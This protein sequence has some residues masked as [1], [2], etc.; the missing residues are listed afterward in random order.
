MDARHSEIVDLVDQ[1]KLGRLQKLVIGICA[2]VALLDGFDT[3]A[4]AFTAPSIIADWKIPASALGVAFA[5]GLLGLMISSLVL[6]TLGDRLGR[7]KMIIVSLLVMGV[8]SLLTARATTLAELCLLRF[9][10]G[11]GLGGAIPCIIALTAE[12][13][14]RRLRATLV[15]SMYIGFPVGAVIGGAASTWFIDAY[16]WRSVFI[17]GGLLPLLLIPIVLWLLPESLEIVARRGED[18][19]FRKL[20]AQLSPGADPDRY[21]NAIKSSPV[22]LGSV[23]RL[24]ATGMAAKT[25]SLWL[26][27]FLNLMIMYLLINWLPVFLTTA[28]RQGSGAILGTVVLNLGGAVGGFVIARLMDRNQ[29]HLALRAAFLG[30]AAFL[31]LLGYSLASLGLALSV[32][33]C[34][35]FCLIGAQFGMNALAASSYHPEVRSTGVGWALGIGRIGSVI[36][37]LLGGVV[38]AAET[39]IKLIMVMAAAPLLICFL[40][41]MTLRDRGAAPT[42]GRKAVDAR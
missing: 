4:V 10:V 13:S 12:Y 14:P 11:I 26:I 41:V 35:G 34:A 5:A 2:A 1:Q 18:A 17:V 20:L 42:G 8:F 25:L 32:L 28:G 36:G 29:G 23:S 37:P 19:K 39:N 7:K 40:A 6:G 15:T 16:G 21:L 27:I 9:C 3:Q 31:C 24:F 33:F 22:A 38:V 30:A